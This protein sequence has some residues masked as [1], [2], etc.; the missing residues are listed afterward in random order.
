MELKLKDS[1]ALILREQFWKPKPWQKNT[2]G[3]FQMITPI[4]INTMRSHCENGAQC[5][6]SES[7]KAEQRSAFICWCYRQE[8]AD[9]PLSRWARRGLLK[10]SQRNIQDQM[11]ERVRVR[12]DLFY[13]MWAVW[14][15]HGRCGDD[16]FRCCWGGGWND[17]HMGC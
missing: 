4:K 2:C 8:T 15:K 3:K 16:I 11:C 9:L 6:W 13:N 14:A 5:F 7:V 10:R 1:V 12:M 17:W